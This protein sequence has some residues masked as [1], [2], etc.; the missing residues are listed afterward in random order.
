M[1][2]IVNTKSRPIRPWEQTRD[3]TT[4]LKEDSGAASHLKTA[5]LKTDRTYVTAIALSDI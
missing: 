4:R 2:I 3:A 1:I 5:L